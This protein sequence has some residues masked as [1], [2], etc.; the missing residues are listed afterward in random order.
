MIPEWV[1]GKR[2]AVLNDRER[3]I[4]GS[5]IL[6]LGLGYK[7]NVDDVRKSPA[8]EILRG[9]RRPRLRT[10]LRWF[11]AFPGCASTASN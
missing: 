1:V 11:R 10:W 9:R 3:S 8:V 2:A 6:V 5:Q 4:K 7:K